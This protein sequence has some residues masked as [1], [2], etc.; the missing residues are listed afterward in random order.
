MLTREQIEQVRDFIDG[1]HPLAKDWEAQAAALAILDAALSLPEE[2]EWRVLE[3]L[4]YATWVLLWLVTED[5]A[6]SAAVMGQ[7]SAHEDGRF[8]DGDIYRPLAWCSHWMPLPEG[9]GENRR[10]AGKW[11]PEKK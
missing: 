1:T 3:T 11:E 6:N 5:P 4:P 9:P 8:W 10:P 7:R 2:R